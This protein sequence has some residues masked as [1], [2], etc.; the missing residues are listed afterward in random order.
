MGRFPFPHNQRLA[1][2]SYPTHADPED[3][4]LA[5]TRFKDE[6][7]T[8]EG[9][10][11]FLRTRRPDTPD[12]IANSTVSEGIAYGM[13]IA[14][15]F[16]DQPLFDALWQYA[17]CFLNT[18][19]LMSWY[20]A[21]DGSRALGSGGATDSDEDMAWALVMAHR[22]WG[23]MGSLGETYLS[24]AQ[25][26][27][28]RVWQFEVDHD[29][30]AGM[31]LPG[32][33][34]RGQNVF[35]P[36]YFAP[37]QYRLFAE[38]SGNRDGFSRVVDRGYEIVFASLNETSGNADNGL[39][40]AWCDATGRPVEAFPGAMTNFQTDSARL[41]FRLAQDFAYHRDERAQRYLAQVSSFFAGI[42]AEQIGDGYELSGKPA[43]DPLTPRPNPGSA[44]FVGCAA[45][46]AQ[47]S[48]DYQAFLDAA[49][50]R[51][52]TGELLARSRYYNHC[53]TVLSL[54]ML[55]GNLI[56]FPE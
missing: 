31:L 34:W 7:V 19:G 32:D 56:E 18:N 25:R 55:T 11:G 53:W 21:P 51:V 29:R 8:A 5:F 15:M 48:P 36:S 23:G 30:H 39:V 43:P 44:V 22:Q 33:E 24:H 13:I 9:A 4:R 2:L 6:I 45:V 16:D 35:N 37:H 41:P 10:R 49:Y 17:S 1:H 27:I 50:A 20:I 12:G 14:V 3:A 54:L 28:D 26:Q 40:P 42:G 46:G 38:I 47:H 52:R